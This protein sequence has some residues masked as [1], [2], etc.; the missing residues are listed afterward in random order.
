MKKLILSLA[1]IIFLPF[2]VLS[3]TGKKAQTAKSTFDEA[4]KTIVGKVIYA[5]QKQDTALFI[6]ECLPKQKDFDR[7][8]NA[9]Y[10]SNKEILASMNLVDARNLLA[11]KLKE[12]FNNLIETGKKEN[13]VWETIELTWSG[14]SSLLDGKIYQLS[15]PFQFKN[16]DVEYRIIIDFCTQLADD[17]Q[18]ILLGEFK[19][20]GKMK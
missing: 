1:I 2:F 10:S 3:Q 5:L 18:V 6:K 19:W 8:F 4:E 16:N 13:I 14:H 15:I 17:K 11:K 12:S 9:T 20:E 7:L